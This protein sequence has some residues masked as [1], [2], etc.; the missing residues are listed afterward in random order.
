M[1]R[2]KDGVE[3][4]LSVSSSVVTLWSPPMRS[5]PSGEAQAA[6]PYLSCPRMWVFFHLPAVNVTH[7]PS[8]SEFPPPPHVRSPV[9]E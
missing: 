2:S 8:S 9:W 4:P 7:D 3:P 6:W 5:T 1:V